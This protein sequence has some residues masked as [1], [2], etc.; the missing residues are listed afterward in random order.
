MTNIYLNNQLILT[1]TT[2]GTEDHPQRSDGHL[3]RPAAGEEEEKALPLLGRAPPSR[4][5][6]AARL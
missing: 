3:H 6:H 2:V 5:H 4:R 1:M